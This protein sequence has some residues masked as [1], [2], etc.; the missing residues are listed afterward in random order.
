MAETVCNTK[1]DLIISPSAEWLRFENVPKPSTEP[2]TFTFE[3][4]KRSTKLGEVDIPQYWIDK[5][6]LF[7]TRNRAARMFQPII[8][9][10]WALSCGE[11]LA[12]DPDTQDIYL[13][14]NLLPQARSHGSAHIV[15]D[16]SVTKRERG[17]AAESLE[18]M[19]RISR[20]KRLTAMEFRESTADAI[21]PVKADPALMA[22]YS[23][24]TDELLSVGRAA[25]NRD[26]ALGLAVIKERWADLMKNIGRHGRD[27]QDRKI[28]DILSFEA[29]AAF[30]TCY[31]VAWPNLLVAMHK[32]ELLTPETQAFHV[33]WHLQH[34]FPSNEPLMGDFFLFRGTPY[35]L[36]PAA[37]L[38]IQTPT[39]QSLIGD[40]ISQPNS[41]EAKERL[42]H[43][44]SV[45]TYHYKM[46][47]D[48]AKERRKGSGKKH[49]YRQVERD[50][51]DAAFDD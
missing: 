36:H 25:I 15:A 12:N 49:S 44:I 27:P 50:P 20:D 9:Y 7:P 33:L 23:A 48:D 19:L 41:E 1:I 26:G 35:A 22:R 47:I 30:F 16:S 11:G 51:E 32:R 3:L 4:C 38:L 28:L 39:G 40:R 31:D 29:R 43:A 6:H 46:L 34:R 5:R 37:G 42:W 2:I 8:G 10:W 45:A 14:A 13:L 21:G 24:I 17:D 18:E